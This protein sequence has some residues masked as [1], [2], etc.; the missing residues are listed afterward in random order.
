MPPDE[1]KLRKHRAAMA[2]GDRV[3]VDLETHDEQRATGF[4]QLLRLSP[5]ERSGR[6]RKWL[7]TCLAIAPVSVVCP[8]HFPWPIVS[9]T[10]GAVGYY[11]RRG[12]AELVLGGEAACPKCGAAQLLDGGNAEFPMAHFC[13]ACGERSL[14]RPVA[15]A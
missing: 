4:I 10:V 2:R 11:L 14:I 8:P 3:P 12:R 7:L 15:S 6:A 9:V 5:E 1:E 13:S